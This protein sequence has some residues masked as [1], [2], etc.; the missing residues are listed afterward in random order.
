M[1]KLLTK[2]VWLI[3][4][5]PGIWLA[6]IWKNIPEKVAMHFD[7]NGVP[8]RF[9]QKSELA[10]LTGILLLVSIGV[11]YLMANINRIDPKRYAL[12]NTTRFRKIGFAVTVFMSALSCFIIY[13]SVNG[14]SKMD[15][16]IILAGV[17]LLL[18]VI[19]NYLPN[20]K[21]NYFAGMRL[22]WTLENPDNWKATHAMAG[23]IWFAGGVLLCILC[24]LLPPQP[25]TILF[26][27]GVLILVIIPS[28]FSWRYYQK[29]KKAG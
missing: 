19:G 20:L 12:D 3:A 4:L 18:A 2:L 5:V 27:T 11:F 7:I 24:F 10:V 13:S 21:P 26:I 28:V 23:K 22:P 14:G 9:G 29:N 16:N 8:D 6:L 15:V 25:A 1:N 17:S